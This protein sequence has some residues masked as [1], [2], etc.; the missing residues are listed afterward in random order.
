[1]IDG[2]ADAINEFNGG[3]VLV[4]HD[5]RLI[6]QVAK[7]LWLCENRRIVKFTDSIAK[8]KES[9]RKQVTI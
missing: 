7:E 2:L 1:A 5:F 4:S 8:Y 3:V 9:L 6:S